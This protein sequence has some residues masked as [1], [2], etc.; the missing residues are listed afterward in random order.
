MEES[1]DL[2]AILGVL[3]SADDVVIRAAFRVLSQRYRPDR[4][5]GDRAEAAA[6]L[7]R[8]EEAYA[9]LSDP[10]R[11]GEY[12]QRAAAQRDA[13]EFGDDAP[14]ENLLDAPGWRADWDLAC[15]FYP[16]LRDAES[17][18]RAI[19]PAL[20]FTFC[21]T[22]LETKRFPEAESIARQMEQAY[23]GKYF[24]DDP[25]ILAFAKRLIVA[26]DAETVRTLSRAL[27]VLGSSTPASVII[28]TLS[29]NGAGAPPEAEAA[30]GWAPGPEA[31]AE[32]EPV[33]DAKPP[34]AETAEEALD[35]TPAEATE[36]L[37][38]AAPPEVEEPAEQVPDEPAEEIVAAAPPE[39]EEPA[40]EP[41][42]AKSAAPEPAP[43]PPAATPG[44][45]PSEPPTPARP[46]GRD[47]KKRSGSI[48][49]FLRAYRAGEGLDIDSAVSLVRAMEGTV[50]LRKADAMFGDVRVEVRF[51]GQNIM[52]SSGEFV[53]WVQR[54]VLP[55]ALTKM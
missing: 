31:E 43:P 26:G 11:R 35:E 19:S 1:T 37:A 38:A 49:S 8:I 18:F 45:A 14:R 33:A 7:K 40:P 39:A 20:A 16:P 28:Q 36:E 55:E 17:Q 51:R 4:N 50:N 2:Y 15:R 27:Q 42:A 23:L 13:A 32:P 34:A 30:A 29:R 6:R 9:T 47:S 44:P 52:F 12:D 54:K 53:E 22:L 48:Q 25:D 21:A 5:Q 46:A 24:G 3:P 10:A 41:P